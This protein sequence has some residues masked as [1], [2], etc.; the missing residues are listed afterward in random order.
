M[1]DDGTYQDH[2]TLEFK[3]LA[4]WKMSSVQPVAQPIITRH[5]GAASTELLATS[6]LT[7]VNVPCPFQA[8]IFVMLVL[9]C[10][11]TTAAVDGL[12]R[13][14]FSPSSTCQQ[15]DVVLVFGGVTRADGQASVFPEVG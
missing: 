4:S 6:L 14:P 1:V 10:V 13:R 11:H 5:T 15:E 8:G 7:D 12:K 2:T 3:V 9:P